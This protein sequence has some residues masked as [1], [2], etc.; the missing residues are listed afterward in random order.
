MTFN[1]DYNPTGAN[2]RANEY[3]KK[4]NNVKIAKND[5][6]RSELG[7]GGGGISGVPLSISYN[8]FGI[9]NA[10]NSVLTPTSIFTGDAAP[11]KTVVSVSGG[12][13]VL[14]MADPTWTMNAI[15]GVLHSGRAPVGVENL[16]V[17]VGTVAFTATGN[18]PFTYTYSEVVD[19]IAV[20]SLR[21]LGMSTSE[22][23]IPYDL[24]TFIS[25]PGAPEF[26]MAVNR[27]NGG[28]TVA[29]VCFP[30]A[31][32]AVSWTGVDVELDE[33]SV[34]VTTLKCL[35]AAFSEDTANELDA[36]ITATVAGGLGDG[37]GIGI[38]VSWGPGTPVEA[39]T[40][41]IFPE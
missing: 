12:G 16:I 13:S 26:N 36:P 18:R 22:D 2:N 31:L 32:A 40:L 14:G 10:E 21:M 6:S 15:P 5:M 30:G 37:L 29:A 35:G 41:P 8:N 33:R 4:I 19:S 28:V 23:R 34:G 39:A 7:V 11:D 25:G 27:L 9:L 17:G 24:R 20:L 1:P 3:F 38:V